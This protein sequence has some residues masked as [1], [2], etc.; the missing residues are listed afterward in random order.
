MK[1]EQLRR[2][3][4][5][6]H[7]KPIKDLEGIP[8]GIAE[9]ETTLEQYEAAGGETSSDRIRKSDLLAI[10]PSKLQSD[11]LWNS[12]NPRE[13]YQEFRDLILTQSARILDLNRRTGRGGVHAVEPTVGYEPAMPPLG[14]SCAQEMR[15]DDLLMADNNP[16]SSLEELLAMVNRQ[17]QDRRHDRKGPH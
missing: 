4:Q 13:S 7:V 15:D 9:F 2:A 1:F 17:R 11:L 10:L 16:I 12:T 14:A 3:V 8:D 6:I 5:M